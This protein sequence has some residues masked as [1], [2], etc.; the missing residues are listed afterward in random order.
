M[1]YLDSFDTIKKVIQYVQN[2]Y[3]EDD[4][5]KYLG[6]TP[7]ENF[8]RAVSKFRLECEENEK[9]D[10]SSIDK[11]PK[12]IE[13]RYLS[14]EFMVPLLGILLQKE[15]W[16]SIVPMMKTDIDIW[17]VILPLRKRMYGM[18]FGSDAIVVERGTGHK[19]KKVIVIIT[20]HK[21]QS[22]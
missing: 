5:L 6:K 3:S 10:V 17:R 1:S 15:N 14:G 20:Y 8:L 18:M 21:W 19:P 7:Y 9:V 22:H 2:Q 12:E 11:C 16:L 4:L 13:G